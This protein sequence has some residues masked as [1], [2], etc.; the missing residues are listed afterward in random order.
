MNISNQETKVFL[1]TS[2]KQSEGKTTITSF[3]AKTFAELGQKVLLIDGDMRRP[4]LNKSFGIDNIIGLSNL[5]SDDKVSF[6]KIVQKTAFDNLDIISAG[7]RPPDP[8]FLLSSEK[9][10]SII[11]ELKNENYELIIFDAP[12]SQGLSDA[13]LI[14]EFS[15]LVLYIVNVEDTNKNAFSKTI[16]KFV[17]NEKYALGAI[18]NRSQ[19]STINYGNY[20]DSYYY[21]QNLYKYYESKNNLVSEN[22]EF[23]ENKSFKSKYDDLKNKF[24]LDYIKKKFKGFINWLDF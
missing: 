16:K 18:S 6:K 8:V 10:K 9:M 3:L 19:V 20:S 2:T 13:Q 21:N 11:K 1:V 24:K 12:P 5:I 15:D 7:I 17:K 4:S 22:N 14:A 23:K